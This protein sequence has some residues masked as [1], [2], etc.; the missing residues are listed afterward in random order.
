[1]SLSDIFV[2]F[3]PGDYIL[4]FTSIVLE[5]LPFIVFGC[6]LSGVLEEL[7]P[8][9]FLQRVLPKNRL[10]AICVSSGMGFL[11]PMCECG[12]VPVMRRLLAKGMPASC[13]V[14]YMLSAP[15]INPIVLWSTLLAFSGFGV[16]YD[17]GSVKGLGMVLLRA[18]AAFVTA[19]TVGLLFERMIRQ[20]IEVARPDPKR[21][22]LNETG[23]S[24][25]LQHEMESELVQIAPLGA[26]KPHVHDENCK[27]DHEHDH[28]HDHAHHR[29]APGEKC[30]HEH[31][32]R[33]HVHAQAPQ[34]RSL[35]NRLL[36]IS[37]IAVGDFLDI[38][39]FLVIGA[40]IA[41]LMRSCLKQSV[42]D[43]FSAYPLLSIAFMMAFAYVISLCSEADAFVA[44]NLTT[45]SVGSKLGF[46]VLGPML[47]VKL[48]I[49]YRWVFTGRA[50]RTIV[51]TLL[52]AVFLQSLAVDLLFRALDMSGAATPTG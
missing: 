45:L 49:M 7:L 41:A 12:I 47:D 34:K 40:A 31:H 25:A 48:T 11:L 5:A 4:V 29:H 3:K 26:G 1:M 36:G 51:V 15:I 22:R 39:A 43:G 19:V 50:V 42:I 8:Q 18:G 32:D 33:A 52:I 21:L 13:A 14:T 23:E 30:E 27:H 10:A 20:G 24:V 44:A 38:V 6:I 17:L 9:R 16:P 28:R 35:L 46:L 37:E 2:P